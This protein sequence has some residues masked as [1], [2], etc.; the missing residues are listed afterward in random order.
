MNLQA[1]QYIDINKVIQEGLR[2]ELGENN[3]SLLQRIDGSD[4]DR[5]VVVEGRR[6]KKT[7]Q[8]QI[9]CEGVRP[10]YMK[11]QPLFSNSILKICIY[12]R[13]ARTAQ[14]PWMF[15]STRNYTTDCKN[16]CLNI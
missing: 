16:H 5:Y 14:M 15:P 10:Q 3:L 11:A 7:R 6:Y 12:T 4:S 13:R 1:L 2:T 9:N 8:Y